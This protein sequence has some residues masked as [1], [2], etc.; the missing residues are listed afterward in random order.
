MPLGLDAEAVKNSAFYL[1]VRAACAQQPSEVDGLLV[2]Q[3]HQQPALGTDSQSVALGAKVLTVGRNKAHLRL[4]TSN[5]KV[6]RGPGG[7][8]GGHRD[9]RKMLGQ[10]LL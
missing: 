10:F 5:Q 9:Q 4:R 8:R 6:P 3:A 1:L 7:I 2:A